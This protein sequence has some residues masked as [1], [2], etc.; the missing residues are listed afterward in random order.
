LP[1][2]MPS[3]TRAPFYSATALVRHSAEGDAARNRMSAVTTYPKPEERIVTRPS[4]DHRDA[5][6]T[7][8]ASYRVRRLARSLLRRRWDREAFQ[9]RQQG[10]DKARK[11]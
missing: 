1:G 7:P 8:P 3:E 11:P 2:V 10:S 5:T 9:S 6:Y 4:P